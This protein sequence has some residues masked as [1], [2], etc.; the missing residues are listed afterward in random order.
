MDGQKRKL[1]LFSLISLRP[2]VSAITVRQTTRQ[3]N[4]CGLFYNTSG[5]PRE[6]SLRQE[7]EYSRYNAVACKFSTKYIEAS[8]VTLSPF[9]KTKGNS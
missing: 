2:C 7:R 3:S 4:V 6:A 1:S 9:V 5:K 8:G